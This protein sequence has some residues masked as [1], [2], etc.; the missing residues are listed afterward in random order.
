MNRCDQP[1]WIR[2]GLFDSALR[3]SL[4]AMRMY[5]NKAIAV[6]AGREGDDAYAVVPFGSPIFEVLEY[7]LSVAESLEDDAQPATR[8]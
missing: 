1:G 8:A 2:I 5:G 4:W 7:Q 3:R 6:C